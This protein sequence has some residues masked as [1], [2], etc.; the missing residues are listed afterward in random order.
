MLHVNF[1]VTQG[2]Q[3]IIASIQRKMRKTSK[4]NIKER[5]QYTRKERKRKKITESQ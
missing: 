2:G 4:Y 1:T 5:I 3:K